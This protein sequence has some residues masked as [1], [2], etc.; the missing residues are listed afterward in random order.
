MSDEIIERV[1]SPISG[2]PDRQNNS[3]CQK[4]ATLTISL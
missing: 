1:G 2:A 3:D 4:E